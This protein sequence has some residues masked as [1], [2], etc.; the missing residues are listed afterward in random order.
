MTIPTLITERLILRAPHIGDF[1]QYE[2]FMASPRATFMGGPFDQRIAWGM[3]S[4]DV[5]MWPLYGH[6]ALMIDLKGT[7]TCIGQV[8]INHGPLFP[9][10]ELG[11]MPYDGFEGRGYASEVGSALRDW[12]FETLKLK[13]LVS[14]FDPANHKSMAVSARLDG[15]A[16]RHC[17]C[18]GRRRC[19][20]PVFSV[21]VSAAVICSSH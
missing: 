11:W 10:K 12:A 15:G 5:A 14:Y 20:V 16:G 1:P 7:G 18:A 4:S 9:E 13:T 8:G 21:K 17:T 19:G 3:F 6:G 2:A